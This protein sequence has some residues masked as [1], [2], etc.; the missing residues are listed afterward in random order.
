MA[1]ASTGIDVRAFADSYIA[2]W[3]TADPAALAE[4]V[5]EDVV[6]TDPALAEPLRGVAEVQEFL[7]TSV[8]AFPDL[9]FS[10]PEPALLSAS[11]DTVVWGWVMEGTMRG[12]VDPPGFAP[13]GKQMRVDGV[14]V[15]QLRD[16]RIGRYRA[17][18]D[19]A[20]LAR[21]LGL[22]PARGGAAERAAVAMQRLQMKLRRR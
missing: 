3:N 17:Y 20:D 1:S 18:Y 2:A 15:W 6:W 13:T 8:Q 22:A 10:E 12:H 9:R 11:G 5:T 16:G 21:Q 14:D 4:L 19:M 7:R